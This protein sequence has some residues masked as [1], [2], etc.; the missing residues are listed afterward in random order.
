MTSKSNAKRAK[1]HEPEWVL[2]GFSTTLLKWFYGNKRELPWRET[3]DPYKVWLSEIM[4]QQTRVNQAMDYYLGFI[5]KFPSVN[6]LAAAKE[7]EVLKMWQGLG[8]YSRARNLHHAA[9]TVVQKFAGEFPGSFHELLQLKGVGKYTAAAIASICFSEPTA[10]VDGNVMRVLSRLMGIR[11]AVDSKDGI[12]KI[13]SLADALLD[14]NNPGDF[15]QAMMEF[16]AIQCTPKNPDCGSCVFRSSC[17][18]LSNGLVD[19]LPKKSKHTVVKDIWMD[20]FVLHTAQKI[21]LRKR[22]DSGIWKNM[23]DFPCVESTVKKNELKVLKE[24]FTRHSSLP[25][26]F[27]KE[28]GAEVIHILSHRKIHARFFEIELSEKWLS[29]QESIFE[30][31][32]STLKKYPVPRLIENYLSGKKFI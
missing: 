12:K 27:L 3:K 18:A 11:E 8:Y 16:G 29:K 2:T 24:F 17:F 13:Q 28:T 32:I 15:N 31:E 14:K 20:Y 7:V 6:S 26:C 19:E 25:N 21:Y 23:Y 10:V 30:V 9:K 1:F 5:K 4:L 22:N